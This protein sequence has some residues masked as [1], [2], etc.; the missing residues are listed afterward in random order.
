M[1]TICTRAML[2]VFHLLRDS[3]EVLLARYRRTCKYIILSFVSNLR[4][5]WSGSW[6]V[7][8]WQCFSKLPWWFVWLFVES[9]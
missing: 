7:G 6:E 2:L 9:L 5:S 3:Y 8:V 1:H 4:R